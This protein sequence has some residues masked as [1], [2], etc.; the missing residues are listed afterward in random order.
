MS[1]NET[2]RVGIVGAAYRLQLSKDPKVEVHLYEVDGR[3]GGRVKTHRFTSEKNQ[4]F[5]AGAMRI[6]DTRMHAPTLN[7][8]RLLKDTH[9]AGL[10]LIPY[11]LTTPGN[12]IFINGIL[13]NVS[14]HNT[15]MALGFN[16]PEPYNNQTADALLLSAIESFLDLLGRDFEA[17]WKLLMKYDKVSFRAY[18]LD[19]N[20]PESVID[21]VE[22]M[23]SQTNQFAL[24][25]SELVMQNMDFSTKAWLTLEDGMDKLPQ[26]LA[27][28]VGMDN[29]TFSA[30]VQKIEQENDQ[31][32][33]YADTPGGRVE[34]TFDKIVLA[35]PPS[36]LRMIPERPRWDPTKEQAI[37]AMYFE[38]LYKIGIRFKTRFW[39]HVQPPSI[40][41]Q[42]T[43]DL[44]IR[45]IVYPSYGINSDGPGVLLLYSW[46]TDA[47][48]WS[49]IPFSE[50]LRSSLCH[51]SKVFK[52]IDVFDQ[53]I[54]A[55]DLAWSEHNPTG[56]AM[57][58]PGQ[59]SQYFDI[60]RRPEAN[61]YF[62]GEHLSRHH[63]WITGAI[64]S[65]RST[66]QDI[67]TSFTSKPCPTGWIPRAGVEPEDYYDS[68][69]Y[70]RKVAMDGLEGFKGDR[71]GFEDSIL[72]SS[73]G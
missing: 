20:W 8:I 66:A 5:E 55:E 52:D 42:S 39:E 25:F 13:K 45:W 57:F 22:T 11:L 62:A 47:S 27:G 15:A 35:I 12:R 46:N 56:D 36:A 53:F 14:D 16:L 7:L 49:S 54:T 18:L 9:H 6:P 61:I 60:A 68:E 19:L 34:G 71:K 41:G 40:G 50:R 2:K 37:R 33:V 26:A 67:I 38:A 10:N 29:I 21:F 51:L 4:Y 48:V 63:T 17:G 69:A 72:H 59:F 3:V 44:P 70:R 73:L 24:S 58:F 64:D 23:C 28:V 31:V 32:K 1:Q 65:G 30:R 43:T